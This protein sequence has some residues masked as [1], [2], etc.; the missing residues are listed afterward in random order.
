MKFL[1]FLVFFLTLFIVFSCKKEKNQTLLFVGSFTDKKPGEGIHVYKFNNE[2]G[3]SILKYTLDNINNTSFL[4]LSK[5]GKFIYSVVESQMDY[6]GKVA[7][8]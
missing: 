7:A 4:R 6:H 5:N 3:E 2:T 1:Q 8:F